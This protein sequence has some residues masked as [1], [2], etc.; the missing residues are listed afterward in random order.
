MARQPLLS[1][2]DL[3]VEFWTQRGTVHAVN[4]ISFDIAPGETLGIVGESGCGKSVT[5]LALMGIL[6]RAGKI[7]GGTAM[8]GD[9]DLFTLSDRELRRIRG[10]DIAMIFQDPMTSLNPVLTI[11]RQIR[12][13]LEAHFDLEQ[14]RGEPARRRPARPGRDPELRDPPQ[15]LPAP[16]L[17]R[18]AAAGDDRHGAGVRAEGPHRRRADDGARR[19]HPGADPRPAEA[20]RRGPRD[21]AHAHHARPRRCR[22]DVRASERHVRRDVHG[23]GQ[24][25]ATLRPPAPPLHARPSAERPAPRRRAE[26]EAAADRR[27]AAGHARARRRPAPS[28]PAVA[29]RSSSRASRCRRSESSSPATWLPAS[30]RCRSRS[31]RGPGRP[32]L[33]EGASNGDGALVE[34][35]NLRVWFPIKS[36]IVLDRHIGDIKAVDD[37]S[38]SIS[39]GETLGL[40]GESGCGKTTVGRTHS[41]PLRADRRQD[42]LRR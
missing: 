19:H 6:P 3:R 31:G 4:G 38:F 25:R 41:P 27:F 34:V 10:R 32:W 22:R 2:E 42:R 20:P 9:R 33:A 24:R 26:D 11:G 21:G 16:V 23:D 40:V 30:T 35:E 14:G 17:R 7:T 18:H 37:V 15:G 5:S 12:E 29:S 39:R 8:F 13:A 28:S 36:G 1:V